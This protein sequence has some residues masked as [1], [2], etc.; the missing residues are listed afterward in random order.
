MFIYS[1]WFVSI[2]SMVKLWRTESYFIAVVVI[3][4]GFV[5]MLQ[6]VVVSNFLTTLPVALKP[7]CSNS[8]IQLER[9]HIISMSVRWHFN[10]YSFPFRCDLI[11]IAPFFFCFVFCVCLCALSKNTNKTCAQSTKSSYRSKRIALVSEINVA[12]NGDAKPK[13]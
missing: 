8:I 6:I 7:T 12:N 1:N 3:L 11:I 13:Y 4:H 9:F 10:Q 2:L 5:L